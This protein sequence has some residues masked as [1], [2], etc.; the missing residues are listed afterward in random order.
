MKVVR[1]LMIQMG[2]ALSSFKSEVNYSCK[3]FCRRREICNK[4]FVVEIDVVH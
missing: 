1:L 3:N 2:T 4:I